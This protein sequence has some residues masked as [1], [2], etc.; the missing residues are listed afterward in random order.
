MNAI[1]T[2]TAAFAT[3]TSRPA[4]ALCAESFAGRISPSGEPAAWQRLAEADERGEIF[5]GLL[6]VTLAGVLISTL[7]TGILF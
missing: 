7:L 3:R 4:A 1:N 2:T 6:R 5:E